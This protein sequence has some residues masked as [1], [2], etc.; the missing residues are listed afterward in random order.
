ME[1]GVNSVLLKEINGELADLAAGVLPSLV[2]IRRGRRGMGAGTIWH[3]DGLIL[4]N[5]HVVASRWRDGGAIEVLLA[6]GRA[7]P[8]RLLAQDAAR[9]V[10]AL[11]ITATGLP[12]MVLGRSEALRCGDLVVALGHPWGV[13]GAATAGMVIT[14]GPPSE[15]RLSHDFIQVGL[16]LRP[17]HSGG[18]MV[19]TRGRL[20]GVNTMINGPQVGLAVPVHEIKRFLRERLGREVQNDT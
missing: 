5:A 15:L 6:D 3:E 8:A 11:A 4:T 16:Q 1:K 10:A 13:I 20:V 18:A 12:T 19:D 14:V 17:G 9:D 7:F 2:Q